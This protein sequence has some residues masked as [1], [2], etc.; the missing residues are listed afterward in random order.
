MAQM[1]TIDE[2]EREVPDPALERHHEP[3]GG[4]EVGDEAEGD[5]PHAAQPPEQHLAARERLG[6]EQVDLAARLERGD[7]PARSEEG[8]DDADP[9]GGARDEGLG[10]EDEAFEE[11]AGP[12]RDLGLAIRAALTFLR[13]AA[14]L[15][16]LWRGRAAVRRRAVRGAVGRRERRRRGVGHGGLWRGLARRRL[17]RGLWRRLVGGDLAEAGLL[18]EDPGARQRAVHDV[19]LERQRHRAPEERRDDEEA[20]DDPLGA[21]L[22]EGEEEDAEHSGGVGRGQWDRASGEWRSRPLAC[23]QRREN[24]ASGG[25]TRRQRRACFLATGY[26]LLATGYWLLATGYW[27]LATGYWLLATGYW[28]L[29][30]GSETTWTKRSSSDCRS[31]STASISTPAARSWSSTALSVARSGAARV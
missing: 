10:A 21:E 6:K 15:R 24:S 17:A 26:W 20:D 29:A 14:H 7:E 18:T 2:E 1:T 4:D 31:G 12:E 13:R 5:E 23:G 3:Y 22:A 25:L 11:G 19:E 16:G 27:L 30:T 9:V 28:L 8:E